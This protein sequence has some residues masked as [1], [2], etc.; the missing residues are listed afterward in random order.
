[1]KRWIEKPFRWV[2][3]ITFF[4]LVFFL[5]MTYRL[6]TFPPVWWDEGWTLAVA[7]NWVEF[8]H[9]GQMLNGEPRGAGLSAAFPVVAPVALS[10]KLFGIGAWQGRLPGLFFTMG[11]ISLLL[12]LAYS[13]YDRKVALG[14]LTVLLLSQ[15]HPHL[16]PL[17]VGRQVL[18]EMP[19]MFFL[20][21]GYVFFLLSL[22][23]STWYLLPAVL[24]WGIAIKTKAQVLPFWVVSLSLPL[25][26]SLFR[27]W[28]KETFLLVLALVG[29]GWVGIL[30]L[31]VQALLISGPMIAETPI[32]GLYEV[33]AMVLSNTVRQ[34]ALIMLLVL[35]LP[36]LTG[37]IYGWLR[38]IQS[39]RSLSDD[40][41]RYLLR[42]T[43]L[44]LGSSWLAWYALLASPWHRYLFPP[45]FIGSVFTSYMLFEL[46]EGFNFNKTVRNISQAL[47][48][49]QISRKAVKAFLGLLIIEYGVFFLVIMLQQTF[50]SFGDTS[51]LQVT[52]YFNSVQLKAKTIES[53]DSELFFLLD[54]KYHYP[55]DQAHVLF[56]QQALYNINT[57]VPY[58]LNEVDSDYIIVGPFSRMWR[59]YNDALKDGFRKVLD[60]E[61]YQVY[62]RL[63]LE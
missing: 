42:L 56:N 34:Q 43:L 14:T 49:F 36:A 32:E 44:S 26:V 55:P 39:Y 28:W 1:M 51:L 16:N 9:Y 40:K 8:G 4:L 37:F 5:L 29:S 62:E 38:M 41:S 47:R 58:D 33:T 50:H 15:G 3:L 10:F 2:F 22:K 19:L 54:Q 24:F 30:V 13:L 18:G 6:D 7:R 27:K 53:Y 45:T 57:S 12:Y 21:A 52:Y 23:R 60:T 25:G 46:T 17:L 61:N 59:V 63:G 35:G 31:R 48:R 11:A 20:L